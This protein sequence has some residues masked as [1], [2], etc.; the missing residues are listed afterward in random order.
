MGSFFDWSIG[1]SVAKYNGRIVSGKPGIDGL[2]VAIASATSTAMT[3]TSNQVLGG[4]IIY[5]P[6]GAALALTLPTAALLIA[7]LGDAAVVGTCFR[8]KIRHSGET[9][10]EDIT[11][12]AGA[13]N[14]LSPTTQ[15]VAG[16]EILTQMV[17]ID[18]IT[19]DSEAVTYYSTG[20]HLMTT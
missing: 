16:D 14:T 7:A 4:M 20:L 3:L 6:S 10:G 15:V 11:V 5:D 19:S 1:N 17:R 18:N 9:S 2:D 13:G 12:T 8:F